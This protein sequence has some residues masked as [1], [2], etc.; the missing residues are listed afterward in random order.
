MPL[1]EVA[2]CR[3]DV[4]AKLL[5]AWVDGHLIGLMLMKS[6]AEV[7]NTSGFV[8]IITSLSNIENLRIN[9]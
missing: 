6:S 5:M 8:I 3:E 7:R 4:G 1:M 9:C 2:V